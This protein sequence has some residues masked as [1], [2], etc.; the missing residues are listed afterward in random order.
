MLKPISDALEVT[1]RECRWVPSI[2]AQVTPLLGCCPL[3]QHLVH[4]HVPRAIVRRIDENSTVGH[5]NIV[6]APS[7][8]TM[9][10]FLD[11]GHDSN[12]IVAR[13]VDLVKDGTLVISDCGERVLNG[14]R[15][16]GLVA[17]AV[18]NRLPHFGRLALLVGERRYAITRRA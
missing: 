1:Q 12:A 17:E 18:G 4:R 5:Q 13:F 6:V 14:A 11:G 8:L 15:A 7:S 9:I 2:H 3:E 16:R 10:R